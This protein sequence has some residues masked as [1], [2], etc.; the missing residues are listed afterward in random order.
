MAVKTD[1]SVWAC[2]FSAVMLLIGRHE[3]N[4]DCKNTTPANPK[5]FRVKTIRAPSLTNGKN[6]KIAG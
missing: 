4:P 3:G 6:R 5:S 2:V 1:G